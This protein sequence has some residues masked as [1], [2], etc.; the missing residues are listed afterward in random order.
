ME[1]ALELGF[2]ANESAAIMDES[3]P[4]RAAFVGAASFVIASGAL[5][6]K[7]TWTVNA[8]WNRSIF[9]CGACVWACCLFTARES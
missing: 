9:S 4:A 5:A 2:S 7:S 1:A 6:L 8:K 3:S